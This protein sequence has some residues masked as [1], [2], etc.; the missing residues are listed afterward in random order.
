MK[1]TLIDLRLLLI[2]DTMMAE[3]SVTLTAQKLGIS[4]PGVSNALSRLRHLFADTL[5]IR[6]PGGMRP[7]PRALELA[8][9]VGEALRQLESAVEPAKFDPGNSSRVFRLAM[10]PHAATVIM[11]PLME[12]LS[13][14]APG[15][16]VNV[17]PRA[18]SRIVKMLDDNE[19]DLA[20][21]ATGKLPGRFVSLDLFSD[22]FVCIMRP[23]NP[24]ATG[25]FTLQAFSAARHCIITGVGESTILFDELL[26]RNGVKRRSTAMVNGYLAGASIISRTEMV[27]AMLSRIHNLV[28]GLSN[29]YLTSREFPLPPVRWRG[30]LA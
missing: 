4:Q 15:V 28:G 5:F 7:T 6:A 1:L 25:Q 26:E 13:R 27:T 2:F 10:T 9:P 22:R 23:D 21:G 20:I 14:L 3:R 30:T 8:V 29:L 18:L 24:L 12:R 16:Q 17:V 11:P 19:V